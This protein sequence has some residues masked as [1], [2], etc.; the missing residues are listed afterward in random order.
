LSGGRLPNGM[1]GDRISLLAAAG[2]L[3]G[4]NALNSHNQRAGERSWRARE[5]GIGRGGAMRH[6][7]FV[8]LATALWVYW[9]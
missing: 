7:I 6:V 5:G 3:S 9:S 4:G 2:C 8:W 1:M